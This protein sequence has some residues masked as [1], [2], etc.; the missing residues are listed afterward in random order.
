MKTHLHRILFDKTGMEL[1][2]PDTSVVLE[3]YTAPALVDAANTILAALANP[4]GSKPLLELIRQQKP[5]T[6]AITISDV[7]RPV[8][9]PVFLPHLLDTLNEGGVDDSGI[10][11]IVGTGMHRSSTDEELERLV[12][13]EVRARVEVIDHNSRDAATLIRVRDV[14]PVSICRRFVEAEFKIV[15]GFVEPHFMA[16][17]SGGRK[18]VCPALA[19]LTTVQR[20][21]GFET[22]A[23]SEA[24]EGNL[25]DN[26]C[27][28][29]SLEIA[30][31]VGVDFLFNVVIS[32]DRKIAAIFCGDLEAAHAQ[33]CNQ[34]SQWTTV[35]VDKPGDLVITCGGGFPL[36]QTF[37]QTVKG[38]VMA[39]PAISSNSTMLL[40]SSCAEGIGGQSYTNLMLRY[41]NEW[42]GFLRDAAA[43]KHE[44]ALDQWQYQMHCR[45]L[46]VIGVKNLHLV[47]DGLPVEIQRQLSVTPVEGPG[48]AQKRA[49]RFIDDFIQRQPMARI[50]VIPQGP[51]TMLKR[52]SYY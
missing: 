45:T 3:G 49:Q 1:A 44:T 31:T 38:M 20:F 26:P 7:T 23:K 42:Q 29:I 50:V 51:Y 36:D 30:R 46:E 43:N 40:I 22:L 48:D 25:A 4:I 8:P 32:H 39:R 19:D 28:E 17:F 24:R 34:V 18:G 12:G 27:H 37:Y 11:I 16:G 15:T 41:N 35:T 10:V 13:L 14:P 6:V 9:N 2:L 33:A 21:H 47:S 52:N 5:K